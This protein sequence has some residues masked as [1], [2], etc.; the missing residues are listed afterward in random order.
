VNASSPTDISVSQ[1]YHIM[2]QV[3]KFRVVAWW[4]SGQTGIAKCDS[5]PNALQFTAP[6]A[7]GGLEGRWTPEDLL[8]NAI[9]S[10][11]TT[12][13]HVVAEHSELAYSDLEVEVEGIIQK[14]GS[15]YSFDEIIIRPT[16]AIGGEQEKMQALRLLEKAKTLCLVSRAVSVRQKFQ[17]HLLVGEAR[18]AAIQPM[19]VI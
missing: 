9:A 14:T 1:E 4:S 10:C 19:P 17:P 3:H 8:L 15:G 5:A 16:L 11:Y 18:V 7:F 6:V 13:F 12:T 2:D